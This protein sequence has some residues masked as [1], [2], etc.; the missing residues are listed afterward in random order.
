MA[1]NQ[2]IAN[3]RTPGIAPLVLWA[4]GRRLGVTVLVP[5]RLLGGRLVDVRVDVL[6]LLPDP[7][8]V[9]L[10]L[11][12]GEFLAQLGD[13]LAVGEALSG[14]ADPVC[15]L[16]LVAL[17]ELLRTRAAPG[18]SLELHAV[19]PFQQPVIQGGRVAGEDRPARQRL[20]SSSSSTWSWW[21]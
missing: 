6:D 3:N 14:V 20:G 7:L 17:P 11:Q 21:L 10:S 4:L 2:T 19:P 13:A 5:S 8:R 18:H 1:N 15:A 16:D 12:L 9:K